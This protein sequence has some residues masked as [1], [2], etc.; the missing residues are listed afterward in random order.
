[1]KHKTLAIL[2]SFNPD[3]SLL[4]QVFER[5]LPQV[6]ELLIVDNGST[7]QT[8]IQSVVD[9][10]QD[11]RVEI[12]L[13][14]RNYG[15]AAAHNHGIRHAVKFQFDYFILLDQDSLADDKMVE[16]L[17]IAHQTQEKGTKV[18]AVGASYRGFNGSESSFFVRF[19]WLGFQRTFC[20]KNNRNQYLQADFLISSGSLY[21]TDVVE[22]IGYM[23]ETLFIDHVDT[24]W[25][26]RARHEG[27]T[28]WGVCDAFMEH[29]LGEKTHAVRLVRQRNIPQHKPFR[30]HYAFRNSVLLYKRKYPHFL[31]KW[32]D[33]Q[34]ILKVMIFFGVLKGPRVENLKHMFKGVWDGIR[35]RRGEIR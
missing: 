5:T 9:D 3:L 30:Y 20:Q 7:Q 13:L 11:E 25:F 14:P 23:D 2:V 27:Y 16:K 18:A 19:G 31:W 29:G 12:L 28:S 26:L 33:L 6:D 35:G 21:K 34:R 8:S 24:E 1:M 4:K 17:L 10:F 15:I 22:T 32:G